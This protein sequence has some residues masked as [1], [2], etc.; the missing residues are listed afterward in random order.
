MVFRTV[1][2]VRQTF[3]AARHERDMC[4]RYTLASVH[5]MIQK[6]KQ[7]GS[8]HLIQSFTRVVVV[9]VLFNFDFLILFHFSICVSGGTFSRILITV[10]DS[11][12]SVYC[13]RTKFE[14]Q[15]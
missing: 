15:T 9:V 6:I 8:K 10:Q 1:S 12:H 4:V 11:I 7:K 3:I 2:A 5:R 14:Q 13:H